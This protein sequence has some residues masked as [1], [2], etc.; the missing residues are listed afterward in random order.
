MCRE[1]LEE[2]GI[3]IEPHDLELVHNMYHVDNMPYTLCFFRPKAWKG[4]PSN[5]EPF[6]CAELRWVAPHDLPENTVPNVVQ[7]LELWEKGSSY[8]E[9]QSQPQL[10]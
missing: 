3:V 6:S 9:L 2:I 4:E 5:C 1:A 7:A 8:S 10:V